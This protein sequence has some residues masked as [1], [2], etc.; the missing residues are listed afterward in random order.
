M[1][2]PGPDELGLVNVKDNVRPIFY[3]EDWARA[4]VVEKNYYFQEE[5]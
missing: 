3:A 5:K 4:Y 2:D 1:E